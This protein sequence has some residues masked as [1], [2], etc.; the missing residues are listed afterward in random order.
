MNKKRLIKI[1]VFIVLITSIILII[2]FNKNYHFDSVIKDYKS[3]KKY[4]L[5]NYVSIDMESSS[6]Y[7]LS[8]DDIKSD[9]YD[10][11]VVDYKEKDILIL[12]KKNTI[13]NNKV[14]LRKKKDNK[15]ATYIRKN[16]NKLNGDIDLEKGYY[17][18][19]YSINYDVAKI[20]LVV[21]YAIIGLI[22]FLM[23][24]EIVLLILKK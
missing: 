1:L 24:K 13:I 8:V 18:N 22:V 15:V 4:K 9:K 11:Y 7:R 16:I 3:Y 23:L 10:A 17:T 12:L 2:H 20:K 14:N 21:L 19:E 6:M 5:L